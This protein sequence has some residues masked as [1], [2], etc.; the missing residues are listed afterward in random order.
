MLGASAISCALHAPLSCW[1][2][3]APAQGAVV[4]NCKDPGVQV[5]SQGEERKMQ[6]VPAQACAPAA[7]ESS[8]AASQL[9]GRAFLTGLIV[10]LC[11]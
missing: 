4:G 9:A 6:P 7:V 5:G 1:L 10:A 2:R 8:L 11:G 3:S